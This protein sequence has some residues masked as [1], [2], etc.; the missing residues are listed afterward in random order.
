MKAEGP[1]DLHEIFKKFDTENKGFISREQYPDFSNYLIKT[2]NCSEEMK[3]I[4]DERIKQDGKITLS[5]LLNSNNI[6]LLLI[7]EEDIASP[8][9][10][11]IKILTDLKE[12]PQTSEHDKLAI[13]SS[14]E[15]I[16]NGKFYQNDL[17]ITTDKSYA[18]ERKKGVQPW[19]ENLSTPK[20]NPEI[21][22]TYK[23]LYQHAR[24]NFKKIEQKGEK[25]TSSEPLPTEVPPI[26]PIE[27]LINTAD[28]IDFNIFEIEKKVGRKNVLP[29]V[30]HYILKK[31]NA[32]SMIDEE[33]FY[34]F[35]I[36]IRDGYKESNPYHN[37]LHAADV[38]QFCNFMLQNG[39]REIAKLDLID[40]VAI[41]ISAIIHDFKHPGVN[42]MYLIN[43][44]S[45]LALLY[46]D[47]SVLEN[48]HCA[49]AYKIIANDKDCDIFGKLSDEE[50]K[51]LR[52]RITGCVLGTDNAKHFD[53]LN[54]LIRQ[55]SAL[56]ICKGKNAEKIINISTNLTEFET[57]QEILL[58]CMHAADISNPTRAF[59]IA[60]AWGER[61]VAEFY[62]QGDK[63]KEK[64]LPISMGCNR[65]TGN[66][67]AA[68]IGFMNG[69]AKPY[70]EKIVEI[71]PKLQPM[72]DN[73]E[74][75]Y[76][77]WQKLSK[78]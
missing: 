3:K 27:E 40:I 2:D 41:L 42:N 59:E 9:S 64:N 19:M 57:K 67:A 18:E 6:A 66:L 60:K 12:A 25:I 69:I 49:E 52:K 63:E 4:L 36:K 68:Q 58:I 53:H 11:I 28:S 47:Q 61:V 51:I 71:F 7:N 43:T 21:I 16:L 50:K 17:S 35:I 56:Q 46:N 70:V 33:A 24:A 75:G 15:V 38:I 62:L 5:D 26:A 14:I 54:Y 32:F 34:N 1:I 45:D 77:E 73:L 44:N 13:E 78:K 55:I 30:S 31:N 39:L 37:D 23:K 8:T 22:D 76:R 65:E 48:Y 74:N 10:K 29:M 20:I 72:L